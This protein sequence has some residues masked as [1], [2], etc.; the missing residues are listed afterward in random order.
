LA[1]GTANHGLKQ[2]IEQ[3]LNRLEKE[4]KIR[5]TQLEY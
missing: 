2:K 4:W 5:T 3:K 1:H